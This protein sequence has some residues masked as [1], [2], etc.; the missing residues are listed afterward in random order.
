M[1][2][3]TPVFSVPFTK[4]E[5]ENCEP[6]NRELREFF[7]ATEKRGQEMANPD[8][9]VTRNQALFESK[10]DL[11]DWPEPCVSR[12]A[13]FCLSSVYGLIGE[14]NGYDQAQLRNLHYKCESWFHLTRKGGYFGPHLH[15]LHAWSGVYCVQHHGDDPE[16]Q[17]GR[18]VFNHP[19]P[20]AIMYTDL[21]NHNLK[22]PF[23]GSPL[24]IRLQPGQL[25]LFP[26]W[27]EHQVYPYEGDDVRITVAFNL[28]FAQ[29]A[30]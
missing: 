22:P 5:L 10:F 18:L 28:R 8:P 21:S 24:R 19:N 12:L 23:S 2:N 7:L 15:A 17:S 6:L 30:G 27:L 26:S 4:V 11:F 14:L 13:K 9:F 1:S 3:I 16:S 25:V 29:H 20:A